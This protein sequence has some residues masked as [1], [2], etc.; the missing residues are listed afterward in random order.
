MAA[1]Q[2]QLL[3]CEGCGKTLGYIYI[4][5]KRGY[6]MPLISP[7]Y[8]PLYSPEMEKTA[9]CETCYQKRMEEISKGEPEPQ[10]KKDETEEPRTRSKDRSLIR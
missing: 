6:L 7:R 1:N 4:G 10:I 5:P 8:W 3:K 9:F 2:Y